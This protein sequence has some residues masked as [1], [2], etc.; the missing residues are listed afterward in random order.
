M[1]H[2][3]CLWWDTITQDIRGTHGYLQT[4]TAT[5]YMYNE[6]IV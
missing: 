3:S 2:S 5:V 1:A 6:G 4:A